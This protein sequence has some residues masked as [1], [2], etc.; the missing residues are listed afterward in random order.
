MGNNGAKGKAGDINGGLDDW[1]GDKV[2]GSANSLDAEEASKLPPLQI[3]SAHVRITGYQESLRSPNSS[4][5]TDL[6]RWNLPSDFTRL[7]WTDS[8]F[9]RSLFTR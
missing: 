4:Y 6:E 5:W 8:T 3:S 1:K 9:Y 7:L 2:D